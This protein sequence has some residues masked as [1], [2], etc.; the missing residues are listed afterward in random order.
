MNGGSSDS[1]RGFYFSGMEP[2]LH[3]SLYI[4]NRRCDVAAMI[5]YAYIMSAGSL[6][7]GSFTLL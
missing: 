7:E 6:Y 1:M 2:V 3:G 5:S 4:V